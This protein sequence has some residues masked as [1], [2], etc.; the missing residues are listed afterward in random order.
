MVDLISVRVPPYTDNLNSWLGQILQRDAPQIM[1]EIVDV[2]TTGEPYTAHRWALYCPQVSPILPTGDPST[3]HRWALYWPQVSPILTTGEPY[4]YHMW[5]LYWP[6][7]SPIL[8]TGEPCT[9]HRWALTWPALTNFG[10]PQLPD[11][12]FDADPS[13]DFYVGA[14]PDPAFHSDADLFR[15]GFP[16]WCVPCTSESAKMPSTAVFQ[17]SAILLLQI[18][19]LSSLLSSS[20]I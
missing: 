19:L 18:F 14:D 3:D 5:A 9:D 17:L 2:E 10:P 16:K 8:A 12:D 7:V 4:T 6:Q 20:H 13:H 1:V 15:L 11:F